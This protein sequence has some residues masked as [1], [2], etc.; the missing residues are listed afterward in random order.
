MFPNYKN[1]FLTSLVSVLFCL[2]GF[3]NSAASSEERASPAI[4]EIVVTAR[5]RE[6]NMQSVPLAVSVLSGKEMLEQ[7]GMK[8]DAI[9]QMAPNVHFEAAGGTSGVKSPHVFI[10]GM[11]QADFIPVEDPAVGIYIDGV[12]MGRNIGSVFDL[13][14][15]ERVEV[16]R[17]PQGTLFGRNT[18]GGAVNIVSS[19]P[20]S[21]SLEGSL[22][23]AGGSD[24]LVEMNATVNMPI[25]EN[26][27]ARFSLFSRERDGYVDAIQY[28]NVKLGSDDTKGVRAR[29]VADLS[30]NFSI[31]FAADY[32]KSE[33]TPGAIT[34]IAGISGFNG[35][36]ITQGLPSNPFPFF[37]N[38]IYS[39]DPA[40]CNTSTGQATNTAC[41][42][43]VWNTGD[44]Y[45]TNSVFVNGAG[46]Q[47]KPEQSV[48]VQGANL[49]MTWNLNN[50]EI[51]SITAYRE[52]DIDLVN[53]LDFSPHI[54][55]ANNH[56]KYAQDQLSQEIQIS[57][58][59]PNGKLNY[60]V[61]LY[62]FEEEG[63]EA[64]PNQI[65]FAPPLSG[66]PD[67]FFQYLDR[68]IDN[69]STAIFAQLNYEIT[70]D[71]RLTVGA[72]RTESNKDFNLLTQRRVGPLSDQFGKLTT[73]ETTPLVSL[74]WDLNNDVMLYAT[75]SEG[76]RD[77]SYAARFTGAV[78][79]PL[80]NYDP[81][82][83]DNFEIGVKSS[84]L[85][86]RVR[87]NLTAFRMDY[88]DIQISASSDQ[89]T[90]AS[91][92]ENLGEATIQGLELELMARVSNNFS[93]GANIGYLDDEIDSL[94]GRLISNTV[95]IG[96]NNDLP[97]TPDWTLSIMAKYE[98][99]LSNGATLSLRAD[100]AA[101]DD[102]HYRAENL[103]ETENDDYRN[104]NLNGTYITADGSWEAT[105]GVRNATDEE[106]YQ[107][108][109]PF[110][111][112]GL[113]FGQPVRP[114]TG[115]LSLQYNFG[116]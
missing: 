34:P 27:S 40:S 80:P 106:Y 74:S 69:D 96:P 65:A 37:W 91:T 52:F 17:G 16:L 83:V 87:F 114:R 23:I 63:H 112:N 79:T 81:E 56:D 10:R 14:D 73:K 61:G 77:G 82:Y 108:A 42:G 75:Y 8:I 72:R 38:A 22:K 32:T 43:P 59:T 58:E 101:K 113:V 3:S 115:Y 45:E 104:L 48:E 64:I 15:I 92:K 97:N 71:L 41:Y 100:Y 99:Q 39:G 11:G 29:V 103:N 25:S 1:K 68:F 35:S 12:Y 93:L 76:Y 85:D 46:R 62:Y 33:E 4:E 66:P 94:T 47:I 95:E 84:L 53:D 24:D 109:T 110:S 105:V 54:I 6:E 18:I 57:G 2:L 44:M 36:T 86:Q 21:D 30:D 98:M 60:L 5:K 111:S 31:D 90:T 19:M 50:V 67:F 70:E 9:G 7:G 89:V 78:P 116:N 28:D 51:K 20:H 13:I 88:E 26:I 49:T 55:F 102:F 107:S